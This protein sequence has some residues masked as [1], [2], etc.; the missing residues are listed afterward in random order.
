[1]VITLQCLSL[2]RRIIP[3]TWRFLTK[4]KLRIRGID[5]KIKRQQQSQ[6]YNKIAIMTQQTFSYDSVQLADAH[7]RPHC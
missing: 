4:W 2:A 6:R 1:M 7:M 3:E 5:C